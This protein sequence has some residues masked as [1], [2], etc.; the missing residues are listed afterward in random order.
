M[1]QSTLRLQGRA[2]E[3]G[4][5]DRERFWFDTAA[6]FREIY[7]RAVLCVGVVHMTLNLP[8]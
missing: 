3:R 1:R 5:C 6:W 7:N 2:E 8:F 4:H